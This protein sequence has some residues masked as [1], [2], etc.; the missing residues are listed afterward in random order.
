M[1]EDHTEHRLEP[2]FNKYKHII[3]SQISILDHIR[4]IKMVKTE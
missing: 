4:I 1:K 2:S 3:Y